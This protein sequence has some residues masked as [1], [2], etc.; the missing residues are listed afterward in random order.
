MMQNNAAR[1]VPKP[2][3]ASAFRMGR[4]DPFPSDQCFAVRRNGR[5]TQAGARMSRRRIG[6]L[7]LQVIVI[8]RKR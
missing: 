5:R 1:L 3:L 6:F 7:R 4:N 2:F 8:A